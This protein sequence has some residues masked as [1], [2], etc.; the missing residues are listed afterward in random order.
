MRYAG[1]RRNRS[2]AELTLTQRFLSLNAVGDFDQEADH[3][4]R[5]SIGIAL[6]N[7]APVKH[8]TPTAI[9]VPK[10]VLGFV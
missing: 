3:A 4:R 9:F 8:P 6:R 5:A 7:S 2:I 10:P 1:H